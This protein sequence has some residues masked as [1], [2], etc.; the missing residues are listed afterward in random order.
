MW[1]H[2]LMFWV[3][4]QILSSYGFS[5]MLLCTLRAIATK[6]Q[7]ITFEFTLFIWF[8]SFLSSYY[9]FLD[10]LSLSLYFFSLCLII[11]SIFQLFIIF[12]SSGVFVYIFAVLISVKF[13][14]L[15]IILLILLHCCSMCSHRLLNYPKLIILNYL[16][17]FL[18]ISL[19]SSK[20]LFFALEELYT[21]H[22]FCFYFVF[23]CVCFA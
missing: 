5:G 3:R 4:T 15:L 22:D 21:F 12:F 2:L 19:R 10:N 18:S 20:R 7:N 16:S 11:Y 14:I 1:H 17:V 13:Q 6:L 9:I 23:F 8:F